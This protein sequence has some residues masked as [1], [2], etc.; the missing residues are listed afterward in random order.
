MKKNMPDVECPESP[1]NI[2]INSAGMLISFLT[3]ATF[4]LFGDDLSV[5]EGVILVCFGLALPIIVLDIVFLKVHRSPSTGLD[6]DKPVQHAFWY[7]TVAVKL[8]GLAMT[9]GSVTFVYWLLPEY[10]GRFY[11]R[12]YEFLGIILPFF[13]ALS[14]PYFILINRYMVEPKDGYWHVGM[15]LAG[16]LFSPKKLKQVDRNKVFQHVLGWLVKLFF[17]PLMFVYLADKVALYRDFDFTTLFHSYKAFFDFTF[18]FLFYIDLLF[19]TVGYLCTIR[20]FDAHIRSAEPGFLGWGVA[21]MCYQPFWSMISDSYLN[22]NSGTSWG[23]W[24]WDYPIIYGLWGSLILILMGVYVWATVSFGVR[25]SNLTHRGILTNGAYRYTKHP[26]Y[27]SKNLSWWL[28]SMP[29]LT[30]GHPVTA[31]QHCTLLLLLNFIYLLRAKTEERHLSCDSAYVAYARY[32]EH[33][34]LLAPIGRWLPVLKFKPGS[35]FNWASG[36]DAVMEPQPSSTT[37]QP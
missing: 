33:H 30:T 27:I 13:C 9:I 34:G 16:M 35:L 6:F 29:F 18:G 10:Q 37:R 4:C 19:V 32:I 8:T 21:L 12:Y 7:N 15:V 14:I 36:S 25:F 31:I 3:L 26:A 17:L 22:Y 23:Y 5:V 2:V 1:T 11:D 24:F 20:L 28:I